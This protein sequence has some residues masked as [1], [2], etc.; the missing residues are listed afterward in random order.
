MSRELYNNTAKFADTSHQPRI[1]SLREALELFKYTVGAY[2]I[3]ELNLEGARVAGLFRKDGTDETY[4]VTY[5][6]EFYLHFSKH[7]MHVP[8][9]GYG[10]LC[11]HN[12]V[13]F[14]ALNNHRI[15]AIFPDGRCYSINGLEFQRYYKEYETESPYIPGEIAAP[16]SKFTRIF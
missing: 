3:Q 12:L 16:L 15:A 6:R 14:A 13:Y 1:E 9:Q 11:N 10:V 7:F 8:E 4:I 2:L 5:K